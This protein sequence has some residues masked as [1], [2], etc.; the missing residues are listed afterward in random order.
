V[1]S[2]RIS[3]NQNFGAIKTVTTVTLTPIFCAQPWIVTS[4]RWEK[5][6]R[7]VG[8]A[9]R[10]AGSR[11]KRGLGSGGRAA[12]ARRSHATGRNGWKDER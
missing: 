10:R 9:E 2:L 7:K 1:E 11:G 8:R 3:E 5:G 4:E 12:K 6:R